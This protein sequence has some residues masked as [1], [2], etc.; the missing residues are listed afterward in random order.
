MKLNLRLKLFLGFI[1]LNFVVSSLLGYFMYQSSSERFFENFRQHKLSIARFI[2]TA[3]DGDVHERM[4]TDES[5]KDPHFMMYVRLI[6]TIWKQEKEVQY[7]YTLNY[8]RVKDHLYYVLDGNIPEQDIMWFE[9]PSF[10]FDY[11]VDKN[12][13]L[14]R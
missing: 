11:Y 7:I 5:A 14:T 12:G 8:D 13:R 9:T 6:N 4:T 3:I 1:T 10:A 2:S